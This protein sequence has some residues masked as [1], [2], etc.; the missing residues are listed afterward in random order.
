[1]VATIYRLGTYGGAYK[2]WL[3]GDI[4]HTREEIGGGGNSG[5]AVAGH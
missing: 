4:V 1:M 3:A 5:A 2:P